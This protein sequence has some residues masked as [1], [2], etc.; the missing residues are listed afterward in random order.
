[1]TAMYLQ[2]YLWTSRRPRA[3]CCKRSPR[4]PV[5]IFGQ[6]Y[7]GSPWNPLQFPG[8]APLDLLGLWWG[9]L[10]GMCWGGWGIPWCL[11]PCYLDNYRRRSLVC[12]FSSVTD[13][14][15]KVF[16]FGRI[17]FERDPI[18][19]TK[20][21]GWYVTRWKTAFRPRRNFQSRGGIFLDLCGRW[22]GGKRGLCLI[23]KMRRHFLGTKT[24]LANIIC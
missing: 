11:L 6:V 24:W 23:T 9:G 15:W 12:V 17:T 7:P 20:G 1:M 19:P 4:K 16:C 10:G 8:R 5:T 14:R 3:I 22:K 18:W 13:W 21:V 2:F